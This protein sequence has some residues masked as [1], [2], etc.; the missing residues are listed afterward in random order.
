MI[1]V[2]ELHDLPLSLIQGM[3]HQDHPSMCS[4]SWN[5]RFV[6]QGEF[7]HLLPFTRSESPPLLHWEKS[8]VSIKSRGPQLAFGRGKGSLDATQLVLQICSVWECQLILA[9]S[10]QRRPFLVIQF[11]PN[12][13]LAR[14]S[15]WSGRFGSGQPRL[16][17]LRET[18]MGPTQTQMRST[19]WCSHYYWALNKHNE[20]GNKC[21]SKYEGRNSSNPS[22]SRF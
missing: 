14:G 10:N 8:M 3:G 22:Q 12:M 5:Q 6:F 4:I 18:S 15:N 9:Q 11:A 19:D 1:G 17:A 7:L 13:Q 21:Q 2:R 16:T 20:S